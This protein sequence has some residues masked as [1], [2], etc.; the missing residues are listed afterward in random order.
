VTPLDYLRRYIIVA[1]VLA[2]IAGAIWLCHWQQGIG[3]ARVQARWDAQK[4]ADKEA[5]AAQE[6]VWRG[7]VDDALA[8][9]AKNEQARRND[10]AVAQR[11][12]DSLRDTNA[13]LG[14]LLANAS[15]ETAR[16]YASAYQAVFADCVGRYRAMGE[17]AQGHYND[18]KS[19]DAA[20]PTNGGADGKEKPAR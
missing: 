9:G 11:A 15:P 4:L 3:E 17:A 16:A 7:R 10:A 13:T 12:N 8:L 2:V 19:V 1:E 14:K 6:N 20:F 18:W 5:A